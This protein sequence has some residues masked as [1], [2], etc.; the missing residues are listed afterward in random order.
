MADKT[1][2]DGIPEP[3]Q[4][5]IIRTEGYERGFRAARHRW[6]VG[7]VAP[8]GG[9]KRIGE[10]VLLEGTA[11]PLT[12]GEVTQI[13]VNDPLIPVGLMRVDI[14]PRTDTSMELAKHSLQTQWLARMKVR[15]LQPPEG[16]AGDAFVY[17]PA[18]NGPGNRVRLSA[19][20]SV[21]GYHA[22]PKRCI[23]IVG[24]QTF[25]VP[26]PAWAVAVR[27]DLARIRCLRADRSL[28][29]PPRVTIA[30]KEYDLFDI[31]GGHPVKGGFMLEL[32]GQDVEIHAGFEAAWLP[33]SKAL[34]ERGV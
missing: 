20:T 28:G 1:Y 23:L 11:N 33:V 26:L 16:E 30:G 34:D 31:T 12:P 4:A 27:V 32:G 29:T 14:Y 22:D 6:Y 17:L 3:G 8:A 24:E 19:V 10:I 25:G 7:K 15:D 2:H 5:I 13:I 18:D 9:L 21:R